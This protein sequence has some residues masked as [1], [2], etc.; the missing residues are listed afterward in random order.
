LDTISARLDGGSDRQL[1]ETE[2]LSAGN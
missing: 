2:E 1:K